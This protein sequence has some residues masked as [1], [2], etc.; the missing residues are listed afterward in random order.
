MDGRVFAGLNHL[1]EVFFMYSG[2]IDEYFRTPARIQA[3]S[4]IVTEKCGF[5]ETT[6]TTTTTESTI[7]AVP[8]INDTLDEV[9]DMLKA[10]TNQTD[11]EREKCQNEM[12]TK[13]EENAEHLIRI[14]NLEAQLALA[15]S[16]LAESKSE[17]ENSKNQIIDLKKNVKEMTKELKA[18]VVKVEEV[19]QI[20]QRFSD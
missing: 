10:L 3:M 5:S 2:C 16:E 4:Q 9:Y 19:L 1:K 7:Q 15:K 6:I 18:A 14:A 8:C 20:Q 11:I 12:I 17:L 13:T